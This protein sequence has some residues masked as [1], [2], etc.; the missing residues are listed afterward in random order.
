MM[1]MQTAVM[2]AAADRE[3]LIPVVVG[4]FSYQEVNPKSGT[5]SVTLNFV[6]HAW[7]TKCRRKKKLITQFSCKSR[8]KSFEPN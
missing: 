1:H 6:A 2:Q 7:S 4:L 8:D 5:I 3:I